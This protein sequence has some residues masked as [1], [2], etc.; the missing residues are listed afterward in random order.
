LSTVTA[1]RKATILEALCIIVVAAVLALVIHLV[2]FGDIPR[3]MPIDP[4]NQ[5]SKELGIS[6][7]I[8]LEEAL[9]LH[10]GG[11]AVF[12]DA[13]SPVDYNKGHISGALNVPAQDL[14]AVW[15]Q[16][17]PKLLGDKP[18]VTYCDGMAC[19]LSKDL[20]VALIMRGYDNVRVLKDGWTRWLK[21][22][23]PVEGT[24]V[25]SK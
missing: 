7:E 13:R 11:R 14:D 3:S 8:P 22:N 19:S 12:L 24:Q 17:E 25:D 15:G 6:L 20:A 1:L 23:G 5:A 9:D 18:I 10:K 4:L 2:R 21:A 16:V